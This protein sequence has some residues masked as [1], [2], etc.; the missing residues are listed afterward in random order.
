MFL[1]ETKDN[2]KYIST[3]K[4]MYVCKI[5]HIHILDILLNI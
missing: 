1:S 3:Y 4:H 5:K 2:T